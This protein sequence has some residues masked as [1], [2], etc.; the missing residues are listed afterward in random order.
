[1]YKP[2]EPGLRHAQIQQLAR[3][4]DILEQTI[5]GPWVLG[6]EM[7]HADASIF[8]TLDFMVG[9]WSAAC[10]SAPAPVL[11]SWAVH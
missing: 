2:L 11:S 4:L 9:C 3:Q 10:A 7:C 6:E 5:E 1:M 8:P